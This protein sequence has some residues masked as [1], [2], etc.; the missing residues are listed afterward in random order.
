MNDDLVRAALL[1]LE[2]G[3]R[4]AAVTFFVELGKRLSADDLARIGAYLDQ[5]DESFFEV[6]IGKTA[7]TRDVLVPSIYFVHG[8]PNDWPADVIGL[9]IARRKRV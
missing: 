1:L 5:K 4:G 7:V 8:L 2:A 9:V 3:E 6:V